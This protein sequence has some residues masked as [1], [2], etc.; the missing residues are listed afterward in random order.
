MVVFVYRVG[1]P[2][3]IMFVSRRGGWVISYRVR[4]Q[5][6]PLVIVFGSRVGGPSVIVFLSGVG[7]RS[8][9]INR[10]CSLSFVA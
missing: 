7:G 5:R 3:V 4:V 9:S 6:G 2:S 10:F 8:F 1:G